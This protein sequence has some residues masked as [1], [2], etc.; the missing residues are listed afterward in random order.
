MVSG[1]KLDKI[2]ARYRENCGALLNIREHLTN[3]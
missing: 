2:Y 1:D 3:G